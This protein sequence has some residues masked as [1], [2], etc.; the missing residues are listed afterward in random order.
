MIIRANVTPLCDAMIWN[1]EALLG[2]IVR[3][4]FRYVTSSCRRPIALYLPMHPL[5]PILPTVWPF[6]RGEF[7]EA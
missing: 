4:D 2:T 3:G 6:G 5:T 1:H 7:A